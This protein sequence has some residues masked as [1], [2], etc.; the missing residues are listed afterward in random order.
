MMNTMMRLIS[1]VG[2]VVITLYL[3]ACAVPASEPYDY[4]Q[5]QQSRPKSLLV[6]MPTNQ[7]LEVA[8]GSAVLAHAIRPL[9]E[10]GYYVF[11]P[12]LV[13]DL[14]LHNGVYDAAEMAQIP[15]A[16]LKEIFG[17]DAVLYID[18]D[19]YGT[20]Y[21]IIASSTE[22]RVSARLVDLNT[23]NTL[24]QNS[25]YAVDS[26]N[27]GT[28]SSLLGMLLSAVVSQVVNTTT[29]RAYDV[30]RAATHLLFTQNCPKCLLYGPYSPY[31]GQDTQL[32]TVQ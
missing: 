29:D 26:S 1:R 5:F 6:L 14:F 2:I 4:S 8:G 13:H 17:A 11:P 30:A 12:A 15:H 27:D 23:G 16:R 18:I 22:A 7:S 19:N 31:Y 25:A 20:S 3:A 24:W 10:A 21:Q 9:A 28:N 32:H